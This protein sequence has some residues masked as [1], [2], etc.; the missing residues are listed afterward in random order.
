[1]NKI[2]ILPESVGLV[3]ATGFVATTRPKIPMPKTGHGDVTQ[4]A[5][6]NWIT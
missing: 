2:L 4:Q 3:Q 1:M 5:G 6:G